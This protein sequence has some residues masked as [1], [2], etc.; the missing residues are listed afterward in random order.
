MRVFLSEA[1]APTLGT[2]TRFLRF[3]STFQDRRRKWSR[4]RLPSRP[5]ASLFCSHTPRQVRRHGSTRCRHIPARNSREDARRSD[6]PHATPTSGSTAG[7][8]NIR[9]GRRS[10][11]RACVRVQRSLYMFDRCCLFVCFCFYQFPLNG[12]VT[13]S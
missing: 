3:A 11:V 13:V 8:P 1:G 12:I 2:Q 6:F 5:R 10:R 4:A 9:E 7:D